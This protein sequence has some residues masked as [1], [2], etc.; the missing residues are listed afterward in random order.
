MNPIFIY[1]FNFPRGLNVNVAS[2]T[3]L[4][5][6]TGTCMTSDYERNILIEESI[7]IDTSV[8]GANGMDTGVL[9]ASKLYYVYIV[10]DSTGHNA[11]PIAV[12]SLSADAPY[13]PFGYDKQ[14]MIGIAVT[15][16]S[17]HFLTLIPTGNGLIREYWYDLPVQ[18]LT[19]GTATSLTDI[20]LS[21]YLP[22]T[23]S[24]ITLKSS[25]T[26]AVAGDAF[27]LAAGGSSAGTTVKSSGSVAAVA[28]D[29]QVR[30]PVVVDTTPN[31]KYLV[32]ASGSLNLYLAAFEINLG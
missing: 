19:S 8:V 2:N 15:D 10:M 4:T 13:I 24:V 3:T 18:V 7:T 5:I 22:V 6:S 11:D 21:N 20:D 25:F 26:P 12:L 32:S 31:I 23:N 27:T 14:K 16:A 29:G 1:P 30:V 17:V 28:V 9:E